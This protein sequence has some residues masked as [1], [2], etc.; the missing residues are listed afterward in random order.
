MF[1][2]DRLPYVIDD[3]VQQTEVLR[4]KKEQDRL[5]KGVDDY[6]IDKRK[7][8]Q[9]KTDKEV[10]MRAMTLSLVSLESAVNLLLTEKSLFVK[11]NESFFYRT[12]TITSGC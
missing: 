6:K 3:S 11:T 2:L 5:Q 7:L 8:D 10:A 1:V 9:R 12:K 4:V